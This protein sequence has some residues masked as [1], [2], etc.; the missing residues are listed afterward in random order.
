[1]KLF[2]ILGIFQL[3]PLFYLGIYVFNKYLLQTESM[4]QKADI[5]SLFNKASYI[6]RSFVNFLSN[7]ISNIALLILVK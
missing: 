3:Y 1:M 5:E 2:D 4:C 6:I 7:N